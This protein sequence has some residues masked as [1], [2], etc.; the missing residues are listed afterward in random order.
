VKVQGTLED[1]LGCEVVKWLRKKRDIGLDKGES[2][3]I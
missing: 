2:S 1:Y 3:K